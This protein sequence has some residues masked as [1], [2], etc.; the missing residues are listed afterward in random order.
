M[1]LYSALQQM[2]L[3]SSLIAVA[4]SL[5]TVNEHLHE[6][7]LIAILIIVQEAPGHRG[8][9]RLC[10][11]LVELCLVTWYEPAARKGVE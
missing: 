11:Q 9:L 5:R 3:Q 2:G 7:L 8:S 6:R 4:A 1:L 10:R